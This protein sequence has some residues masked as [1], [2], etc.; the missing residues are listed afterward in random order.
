MHSNL[1]VSDIPLSLPAVGGATEGL[2][3]HAILLNFRG[4]QDEFLFIHG[5]KKLKW[6]F[7]NCNSILKRS[8]HLN[9]AACTEMQEIESID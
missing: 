4:A 7:A 3:R 8:H 9:I 1:C 6:N 5:K 2:I